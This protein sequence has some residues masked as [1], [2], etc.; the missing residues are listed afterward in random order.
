MATVSGRKRCQAI[1][2]ST[3]FD[4]GQ[5]GAV[6]TK[7][8]VQRKNCYNQRPPQKL[9]YQNMYHYPAGRNYYTFNSKTMKSV[10][11][12][13]ILG[14]INSKQFKS[15]SAMRKCIGITLLT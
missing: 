12:S 13:A 11:V 15:G 1:V 5:C 8:N 9:P 3:Q 6:G 7:N 10:G 2:R 14:G 4:S